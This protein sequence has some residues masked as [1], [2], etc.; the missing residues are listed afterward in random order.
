LVTKSPFSVKHTADSQF[1]ALFR[2]K[3]PHIKF[4]SRGASAL[5]SYVDAP[6]RDID[7]YELMVGIA[8]R[9]RMIA[10]LVIGTFIVVAV[11]LM[12][13]KPRYSS[14]VRIL[15]GNTEAET[16]NNGRGDNGLG[17]SRDL[18]RS[19]VHVL[20]SRDLMAQVITDL[21]LTQDSEF[22][23][24]NANLSFRKT[25]FI[26]LGFAN[27]PRLLSPQER[28][29]STLAPRLVVYPLPDSRVIALDVWSHKPE[30]AASI[31]NRLAE[32]YINE[33]KAAKSR[34]NRQATE[35]LASRIQDLQ[36]KVRTAEAEVESFRVQAGLLQGATT[37][38]NAQELSE[39]NSQIIVAKANRSQ[40]QARARQ[41][42]KLLKANG[43]INASTE[44]LQ[45]PFI[46]RLR[47]QQ[48]TL[49]RLVADLSSKYLPSHPRMVRLNA[50]IR[51][52][53][54]QVRTEMRKIVSS[55]QGQVDVA[56]ARVASLNANLE[57][58]KVTA[59]QANNSQVRLK[60]L[61]RGAPQG[62]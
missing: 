4:N 5:A 29:W 6:E 2:M 45:S 3:N 47:E 23:S 49:R 28:A 55:L 36:K 13:T 31:A 1:L 52:L 7:L 21:N 18:V 54:R 35:W 51:D 20:Q 34:S 48:V 33:T 50:E 42:A 60:E 14:E 59:G 38:L 27:D 32:V 17:A 43:E 62:T 19:Q 58:V 25:L 16:L 37:T 12:L 44:V 41:I 56:T 39:I 15:F 9:W 8:R 22:V 61:E 11:I 24:A 57:R 26:W 40:A 46:R 30:L 10:V 53:S